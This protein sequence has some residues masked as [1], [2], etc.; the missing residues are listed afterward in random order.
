MSSHHSSDTEVSLLAVREEELPLLCLLGI[1]KC[2][3]EELGVG[4]DERPQTIEL[5]DLLGRNQPGTTLL[6]PFLP[7]CVGI[8]LL[9][10]TQWK[11][12]TL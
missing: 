8:S 12:N 1:G 6:V 5:E 4:G 11:G 7:L 9:S 10:S 2:S 3:S